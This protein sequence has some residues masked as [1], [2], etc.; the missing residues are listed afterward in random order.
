MPSITPKTDHLPKIPKGGNKIQQMGAEA[1]A[2]KRHQAK[3]AREK[4]RLWLRLAVK[5]IEC[6]EL[7]NENIEKPTLYDKLIYDAISSA[8]KGSAKD[9]REVLKIVTDISGEAPTKSETQ[10]DTG[11]QIIV[12]SK[13]DKKRIDN[14]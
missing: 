1:A 11:I 9:K 7:E 3:T 2:I 5:G 6:D 8:A 14:V 4:M 13:E 10:V 12:Q